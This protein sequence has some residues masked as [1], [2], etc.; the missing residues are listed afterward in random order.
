LGASP[1][2]AAK[3]LESYGFKGDGGL[4]TREEFCH[5]L[6]KLLGLGASGGKSFSDVTDSYAKKAIIALN[7][8]KIITA[9]P[10][11]TFHPKEA[12][13]IADAKA[14]IEKALALKK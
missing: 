11:G 4:V 2:E 8:K 3:A 6:A 13:D 5:V 7:S 14:W 12:I 10:D 1:Q 9:Y